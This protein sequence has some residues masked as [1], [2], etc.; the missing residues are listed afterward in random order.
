MALASVG[1]RTPFV[2]AR[3]TQLFRLL[4]LPIQSTGLC[5]RPIS[6]AIHQN[7][8]HLQFG[9][10]LCV[11]GGKFQKTPPVLAGVVHA[12]S[13][14][15][16]YFPG[17]TVC[18]TERLTVRNAMPAHSRSSLSLV[19]FLTR[20]HHNSSECMAAKLSRE[21]HVSPKPPIKIL[22]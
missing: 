15:N 2:Y 10:H 16:I 14:K 12:T 6:H 20:F 18:R 1:H 9:T 5:D 4:S 11:S 8:L 21:L 22:K 19:I 13:N 17:N 3:I 7:S